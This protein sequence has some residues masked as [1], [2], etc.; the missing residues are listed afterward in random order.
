MGLQ[1][2]DQLTAFQ[3]SRAC[4][5]LDPLFEFRAAYCGLAHTETSRSSEKKSELFI[6][7][8]RNFN[9]KCALLIS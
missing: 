1:N 8:T 9:T 2:A 5:Q 6:K 4:A 7:Y 3:E